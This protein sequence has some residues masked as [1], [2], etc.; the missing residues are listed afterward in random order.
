MQA[1]EHRAQDQRH[2][3]HPG[4]LKAMILEEIDVGRALGQVDDAAQVAEQRHFD[5]GAEQAH[6]EQGGEARPDLLEVVGVEGKD[7]VG[8]RRR[9]GVTENID[10]LF[11]TAIKHCVSARKRALLQ[12]PKNSRPPCT[13]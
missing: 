11:K 4:Q 6:G 5:Q 9:R 2:D 7:T 10:Q 3:R 12:T 8:R 13:V 1:D